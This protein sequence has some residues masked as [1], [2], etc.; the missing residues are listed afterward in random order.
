VD[1][2][3]A[4]SHLILRRSIAELRKLQT[5]RTIHE[6]L[7]D[8]EPT[9]K[10]TPTPGVGLPNMDALMAMA[11]HQLAQRYRESGLSSFCNSTPAAPAAAPRPNQTPE[12]P[13]APAVPEPNS[14]AA[15]EKTPRRS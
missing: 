10:P 13:L 15:A 8:K 12:T 9:P 11:D 7:A 14:N 3:R 4:Q 5:G 1:R 2:A 6:Q